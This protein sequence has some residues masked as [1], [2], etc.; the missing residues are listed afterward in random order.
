MKEGWEMRKLLDICNVYQP[1]TIS[2]KELK[3]NGKYDVFGANGVIGKYDKYNH[4]E[5]EVLLTCRG[6][7]CG[8]INISTPFSWINGNAMVVHPK[9]SE[10][11][12]SFLVCQLSALDYK[13]IISGA[14][15]P[16]ITRQSLSKVSIAVPPLSEQQQIVSFLDSEFAKIEALKANAETQLQAAKDLFQKA[17]KEML[18]PKDGWEEKKLFELC[19]KYG[20]YGSNA[21]AT[22]YNSVRYIRITDITD[23]GE[24][25]D[26]KVSANAD[27]LAQY[28]LENCDLLFARTGATVGK[29]LLYNEDMGDCVYAGYLIRY[30]IN[31]NIIEPKYIFYLC[32][33]EEYYKWIAENQKV[34]AQPNISAKLYNNYEVAYPNLDKQ[35][36]IVA[37]LDTLSAKIKQLEK[38]CNE[39]I[40]LCN[41]LKQSLLKK[42]FE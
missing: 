31:H 18:T 2:K 8:N 15:Q 34:G 25:N 7:T 35:K 10:L 20:E 9:T 3:I 41:D 42:I 1:T 28:K 33:S 13:D 5:S 30:R 11:Q 38:N 4:E 39:T 32:H 22:D 29:T 19:T 6:A 23:T 12:K 26:E 14:A 24:L 40:T 37:H 36:Q 16:Q 27:N 17:L 21:S